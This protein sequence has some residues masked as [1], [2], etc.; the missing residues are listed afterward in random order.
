MKVKKRMHKNIINKINL[1][2]LIFNKCFL[3]YYLQVHFE[4]FQLSIAPNFRLELAAE[5]L[6]SINL[7]TCLY[8]K[9]ISLI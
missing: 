3:Y 5:R 8:P 7:K 9:I 2:L 1:N 6:R 4:L